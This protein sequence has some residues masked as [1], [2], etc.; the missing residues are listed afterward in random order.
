M[1]SQRKQKF[2]QEMLQVA[3]P[4]TIQ[5]LFQSSLSVIDQMMVGSLGS[6]NVAGIGLGGKFSSLFLVTVS[7]LCTAASILIAQYYGAQ[8]HKGIKR[9]FSLYQGLALG[10]SMLFTIACLGMPRF[11]MG[12]YSRD[13]AVIQVSATY[14]CILAIGFIPVTFSL[15]IS[16][17]CR[18]IGKAKLPMYASVCSI[19]V[20]TVLN[21]ILIYGKCGVPALGIVGAAWA[22]TIAR[23]VECVITW[24]YYLSVRKEIHMESKTKEKIQHEFLQKVW[25]MTYPI[26]ICEFLWGL[27]EN[28]YAT[29][30]GRLGT[31]SCAAMTLT[32]PVQS[33]VIGCFSG[34]AAATGIMLGNKLGEGDEET[35]YWQGKNFIKIGF[36][37]TLILS[38]VVVFMAPF[39]VK[40][41]QVESEVRR[42][43]IQ[44]LWVYAL[45][46][47]V[48]VLNMI[49]EGGILRSGGKTQYTLIL[50]MIGTW[51]IGI[52]LGLLGT[53]VFKLSIE[54]VY[55]LLS[56]EEV[57][58]L[59][60]AMI[61]F[62][63]KRWIN[64]LVT[65]NAN[66]PVLNESI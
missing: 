32:G 3:M 41:F 53:Y 58:R 4:V 22:T 49:A 64:H 48:K 60:L 52:P 37:G 34:V 11:W 20:N 47:P 7:A 57:V 39:Y 43:T 45:I 55:L 54:K 62:K 19:L 63:Q 46:V 38:I 6:V 10:L 8:D 56:L 50:D 25:K 13:E 33:L 1:I 30:Y 40:I 17:L 35:A 23:L 28:I 42:I 31:A 59:S 14:L 15:M 66:S 44:I 5:S 9:T 29:M 61:I 2:Y 26:L 24:G 36:L 51:G 65:S 12:F 16:T 27:G 21:Y 18:S